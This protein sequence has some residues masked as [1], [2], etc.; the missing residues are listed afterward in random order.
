MHKMQYCPRRVL[1]EGV[2][3]MESRTAVA[4]VLV[5]VVATAMLAGCSTSGKND[6]SSGAAPTITVWSLENQPDRINTTKAI[7]ADFTKETGVKVDLVAIDEAQ[8]PQL[9]ASSA[10][11]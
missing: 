4:T 10:L 3:M 7:A 6:S 11:S 5:T 9:V 2:A 1:Q 8:F